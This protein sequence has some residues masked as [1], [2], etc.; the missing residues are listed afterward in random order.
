M[1]TITKITVQEKLKDR[2][3]IF[4][5][6]KYA[7]SI[8]EDV[9]IKHGLKK[10]VELDEFA[11]LEIGYQDD[12]RKAYNTAIQYL[13]RRMRSEKEVRQYLS[14]KEVNEIVIQEVIHKLNEYK[15]LNDQEFAIAFVRTLMN[16]T[17][18]GSGIIRGELREKGISEDI[19]D[20]A[21]KEFPFEREFEAA[22]KICAKFVEKNTR[23]SSRITKQK[24]EQTLFRKGYSN[25]IIRAAIAETEMDKG[26]DL[27]MSALRT[28]AEKAHRKYSHLSGFEYRQKMKQTLYRKGFSIELIEQILDEL[29]EEE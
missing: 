24:L 1:P 4:L 21:M 20:K 19:I 29:K 15:F 22:L 14:G 23:D 16:T 28:H 13:S 9:L 10:G 25:E 3:N 8:D 12:I 17:D 6:E 2:Y 26:E 18:K 5:D 27:E 7:F 11:I